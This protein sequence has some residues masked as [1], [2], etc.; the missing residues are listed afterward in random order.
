MER[1]RCYPRQ[2]V[3][4]RH[5][6]AR[7]QSLRAQIRCASGIGPRLERPGPHRRRQRKDIR[8][9]FPGRQALTR[10]CKQDSEQASSNTFLGEA[11]TLAD[12][13]IGFKAYKELD[14][15]TGQL[16]QDVNRAVILPRLDLTRERLPG[17]C[18]DGVCHS[19]PLIPRDTR[20]DTELGRP[21]NPRVLRQVCEVFVRR[22]GANTF[23]LGPAATSGSC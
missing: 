3:L 4:S 18:I 22:P 7:Y 11:M 15:R 9:Q 17:I 23:F 20:V 14:H 10:H 5:T 12:A 19:A 16:W 21:G 2:Q 13:V 6:L 8:W 1:V